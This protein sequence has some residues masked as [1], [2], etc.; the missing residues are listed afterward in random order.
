[1]GSLVNTLLSFSMRVL[2]LSNVH[3]RIDIDVEDEK[4]PQILIVSYL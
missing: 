3:D 2:T 1:M 4:F